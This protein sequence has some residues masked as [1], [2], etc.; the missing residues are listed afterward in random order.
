MV[1]GFAVRGQTGGKPPKVR[2]IAK[3]TLL[4]CSFGLTDVREKP[5]M[6]CAALGIVGTCF[7]KAQ[8]AVDGKVHLGGIE[9]FLPV[10]LPPADRA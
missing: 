6:G 2:C 10:V 3:G 5:G 4:F 9:V 8:L 1:R 7:D